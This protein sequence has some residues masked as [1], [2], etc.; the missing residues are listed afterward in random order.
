MIIL[1]QEK[2]WKAFKSNIFIIHLNFFLSLHQALL[3]VRLAGDHFTEQSIIMV[4]DSLDR[5]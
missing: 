4:T 5:N 3:A 2:N 1:K